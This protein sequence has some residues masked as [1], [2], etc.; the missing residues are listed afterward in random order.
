MLKKLLTVVLP[1]ALPFL[2]Y[3]FYVTLARMRGTQQGGK[4][5]YTDAP[6][7]WLALGGLVLMLAALGSWRILSDPAPPGAKIIP[8][9]YIDGEVRPSEVIEE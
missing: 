7:H 1:I 8:D 6:W 2:V 3:F 5:D 9:R 4:P